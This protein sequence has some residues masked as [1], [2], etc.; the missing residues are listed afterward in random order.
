MKLHIKQLS[1][2]FFALFC[3]LLAPREILAQEYNSGGDE[4]P[5]AAIT[6]YNQN[7]CCDYWGDLGKCADDFVKYSCP[8]TCKKCARSVPKSGTSTK[9]FSFNK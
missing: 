8:A 5:I 4:V 2:H 7:Y 6:C 3:L 1:R 9:R